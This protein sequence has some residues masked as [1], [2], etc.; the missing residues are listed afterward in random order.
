MNAKF[1]YLLILM[2]QTLFLYASENISK[3]SAVIL[4]AS[5]TPNDFIYFSTFFTE[6]MNKESHFHTIHDHELN[7]VWLTSSSGHKQNINVE[8][9]IKK[10]TASL[11]N[12][13]TKKLNS[14]NSGFENKFYALLEKNPTEIKPSILAEFFFWNAV[15]E[16]KKNSVL[17][18]Q[19][20]ASLS[21][22]NIF[23]AEVDQNALKILQLT[24]TMPQK[25][26]QKTVKIYN[27]NKCLMYMNGYLIKDVVVT[28]PVGLK[29]V[30]SAK[31]AEGIFSKI[32]YP[33]KTNS[34]FIDKLTVASEELNSMP[35]V[36]ALPKE[37]ILS[38]KFENIIA[39]FW[40]KKISLLEVK[41]FDSKNFREMKRG[42]FN[43]KDR[44]DFE[45]MG[46]KLILFL[47]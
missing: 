22:K 34:I 36:E 16:A 17:L 43:V 46:D 19:K 20:Y 3:P 18:Y 31:C 8:F 38:D 37:K 12:S 1:L 25:L 13:Y 5:D 9:E 7:K 45:M 42:R 33:E 14:H 32:F 26:S 21:E 29:S 40:S 41:V 11:K 24:I 28:L 4:Y 23:E 15:S 44:D 6:R 39:I 2:T 47:A 35:N 30:L 27:K 10:M